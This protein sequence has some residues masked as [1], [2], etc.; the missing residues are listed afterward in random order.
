VITARPLLGICLSVVLGVAVTWAGLGMAYY[1]PYPT[2][3]FIT[4]LSFAAYVAARGIRT[5]SART[6]TGPAPMREALT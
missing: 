1:T 4:T 5:L 3:A 6:G 2:G